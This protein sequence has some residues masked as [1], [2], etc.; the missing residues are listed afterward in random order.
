MGTRDTRK[1]FVLTFSPNLNTELLQAFDNL[2]YKLNKQ[3]QL[4]NF[5]F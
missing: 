3:L 4:V 2:Q 1:H 5:Y